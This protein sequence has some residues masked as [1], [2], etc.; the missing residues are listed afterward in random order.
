VATPIGPFKAVCFDVGGV[1]TQPMNAV[2]IKSATD[3]GIDLEVLGPVFHA[4]FVS[5]GDDET[6]GHRL[7][8]GE[9]TIEEF[10][11]IVGVHGGEIRKVLHPD[12]EHFAMAKLSPSHEMHNLVREVRDAGFATGIISNVVHE[13]MPWWDKFVPPPNMFDTILYS[14]IVG[15]RKPNPSIYAAAI[16][17]L[18]VEPHEVLYLDDFEPMAN[19]ARDAGMHVVHVHDH[20]AAIA[21]VRLTLAL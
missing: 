17:N 5:E 21:E 19:A 15:L 18:N 16:A 10:L 8:R 14:C 2:M 9:I 12:S 3:A 11:D 13:W 6:P 7:E 20:S 1:L 4:M